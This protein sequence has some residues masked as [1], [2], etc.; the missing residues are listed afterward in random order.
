MYLRMGW[1]VG[2]VGIFS[3][4]VIVT[5][6]S[7]ITFLTGLSISATATNMRVGAG[8][9]Y[10][11]ISRS[12]GIEA[13][14][15]IGLPL[16][17]A[18]SLG[19]SFYISGFAE[20]V[21]SLLPGV[22]ILAISLTSIVLLTIIAAISANLA[23]KA[24]FLIFVLIAISLVSFFMGTAPTSEVVFPEAISSPVGFWMAFAVFFPAVTG[25]EAGLSMSGDLKKPSYSL[26][27]G[28]LSAVVIS[29]FIYLAIPYFLWKLVP[30][31]VLRT[32]PMIMTEVSRVSGLILLGIWG[33]TLSSALGAMLG[34]PRTLQ[35]LARDRVVPGFLGRGSGSTDEPRIAS[36]A[37][38]LVGLA[39]LLLGDLNAIAPVLSM[40]F[41]TSYGI[42]NLS[43]GLEGMIGN[44]SWRPTFQT[45][46]ILSLIGAAGCFSAM[47]M[48]DAGAAYGAIFF[49]SLVYWIMQKRKLRARWG[50]IRRSFL[51]SVARYAIYRLSGYA[52]NT[53][54]WRP[55]FLVL[56]G[57]PSSHWHLIQLAN[58][59]GQR[60]SFLT[61]ASILPRKSV[62]IDRV[63]RIEAS[64]HDFL[65]KQDVPALVD[66]HL[67]DST[68]AGAKSLIENYGLGPLVPDT[69]L[70]G[71]TEREENFVSFSELILLV[72]CLNRNLIVVREGPAAEASKSAHSFWSFRK[73]RQQK[74]IDLWWGGNSKSV[75]LMLGLAY[76]MQSSPQWRGSQLVLKTLVQNED[77]RKGILEHMENFIT[78]GRLSAE[79]DVRIIS[80][81]VDRFSAIRQYSQD[82]DFVFIGM[83]NPTT[84]ETAESY[85]EYYS[86]LIKNTEALPSTAFVL[87]G[88]NL[89]FEEIFT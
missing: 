32:N 21:H 58:A 40:F 72:C 19:I 33:A 56:S 70:I 47:L 54:S 74:R 41:L 62:T 10:Y 85:S 3:T 34:A 36:V 84:G 87:A 43:A 50:D 29:Y 64:I 57:S 6:A 35:A 16:F 26:P 80:P 73:S 55:H 46:W 71:E 27:L 45:P 23:L 24:Q 37:S 78:N 12:F 14:A 25:I 28:T 2:H 11:M 59:I 31:E 4:F 68:L 7:A 8:G 76:M 20:S 52:K 86:G 9:A 22:P 1:V 75:N 81:D 18:Q 39:G 49:C 51:L 42:L 63:E 79:L 66:V 17:F 67:S 60:K 15:A 5:M 65:V 13:G 44:P 30:L 83:R 53:R 77:Q 48:I 61:V 89:E 88:E 69:I 82:A 38:F